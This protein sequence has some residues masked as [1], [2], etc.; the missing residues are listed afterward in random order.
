[1]FGDDRKPQS[2]PLSPRGIAHDEAARYMGDH[3]VGKSRAVIRYAEHVLRNPQHDG[4]PPVAES[5]LDQVRGDALETRQIGDR[6]CSGLG[7]HLECG[8]DSLRSAREAYEVYY[9]KLYLVKIALQACNLEE[10]LDEAAQAVH[11]LAHNRARTTRGQQLRGGDEARDRRA[12]LMRSIRR[13]APF[14]LDT[15]AQRVGHFVNGERE[16]A[17]LVRTAHADTGA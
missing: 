17:D 7:I 9:V 10:L 11:T 4:R 12:Q 14:A 6:R 5:I 8:E 1:M 2:D 16:R 13:E 15:L 3:L